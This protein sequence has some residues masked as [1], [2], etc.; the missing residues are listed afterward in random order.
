MK[1]VIPGG[2]GQVGTILAR[3]FQRD[4]H[5]VVVLAAAPPFSRGASWNGMAPAS[6]RGNPRSMD[7]TPSS[8]SPGAA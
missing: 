5:D 8:T 2:S 3:A 1:I 4:G 7:A 6:A